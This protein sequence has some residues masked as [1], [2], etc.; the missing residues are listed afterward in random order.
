[1]ACEN[2]GGEVAPRQRLFDSAEWKA[3]KPETRQGA[4]TRQSMSD[5]AVNAVRA[6]MTFDQ[7]IPLFGQPDKDNLC[8]DTAG[9]G[10]ICKSLT[11]RLA[12]YH[13]G[14]SGDTKS[15]MATALVVVY[16]PDRKI[17]AVKVVIG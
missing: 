13:M 11:D 6:L 12:L 1:M 8:R 4:I 16:G 15:P 2:L 5:S 9:Y 14:D 17:R 3:A 10:D 7:V